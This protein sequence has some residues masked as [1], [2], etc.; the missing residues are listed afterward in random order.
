MLFGCSS[1]TSAGDAA[2]AGS[3]DAAATNGEA[4]STSK[5]SK[6]GFDDLTNGTL[7]VAGVEFSIP[8]YYGDVTSQ[9]GSDFYYIEPEA[10]FIMVQETDLKD[11][12]MTREQF[13]S[14]YGDQLVQGVIEG[15][16]MTLN[17]TK[18]REVAGLSALVFSAEGNLEGVDV[19]AWFVAFY[20]DTA[21]KL[22]LV[23]LG[24]TPDAQYDYTGD[25]AKVIDSAKL[26]EADAA[27]DTEA[28]AEA[29]A[30]EAQPE[31]TDEAPAESGEVD[32]ELKAWLDSYEAFV[33]EYVA[34]ME[35]YDPNDL[36]AMTSYLDMLQK[37]SDFTTQVDNWDTSSMSAADYAYYIEVTSRCAEKMLQVSYGM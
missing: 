24:Q 16:G 4:A 31:S 21:E 25:F 1:G 9:S 37:Y 36:S 30:E 2:A 14:M 17:S 18:S 13:E 6:D 8:G 32:P 11:S 5:P 20:N 33:D 26:V 22:G 34:F 19:D 12:G 7:E 10:A 29:P 3:G 27:A 28:E 35:N 15:S 23:A